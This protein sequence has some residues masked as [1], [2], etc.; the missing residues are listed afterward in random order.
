M[1]RFKLT[2]FG[3]FAVVRS[4]H[5]S[6]PFLLP[7]FHNALAIKKRN[8]APIS[9]AMSVCPSACDKSRTAKRILIKFDTVRVLLT[10]AETL[11]F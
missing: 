5:E 6:L 11:Q 8:N 1:Y 10:S 7:H 4:L 9:I 2:S 3:H